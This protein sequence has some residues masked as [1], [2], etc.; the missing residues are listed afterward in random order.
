MQGHLVKP[1]CLGAA[2]QSRQGWGGP[3]PWPRETG[4]GCGVGAGTGAS[5]PRGKATLRPH[6]SGDAVASWNRGRGGA[7]LYRVLAC[8]RL[9][10]PGFGVT[11]GFWH[12]L[13]LSETSC[14]SHLSIQTCVLT[15]WGPVLTSKVPTPFLGRRRP[16]CSQRCWPSALCLPFTDADTCAG[17]VTVSPV[18]RAL[19][20]PHWPGGLTRRPRRHKPACVLVCSPCCSFTEGDPP[21]PMSWHP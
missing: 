13:A 1:E 4:W 14:P 9:S 7:Q 3:D 16:L 8:G 20:A 6:P 19:C 21:P 5:Q 2:G 15:G 10:P 18:R 12:L 11:G 17:E